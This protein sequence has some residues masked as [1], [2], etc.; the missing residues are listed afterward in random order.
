[1]VS[2]VVS[3]RNSIVSIIDPKKGDLLLPIASF[4]EIGDNT[5]PILVVG[6]QRPRV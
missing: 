4:G 3:P 5:D 1:M 2:E 6:E